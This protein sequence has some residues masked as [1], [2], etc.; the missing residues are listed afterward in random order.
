MGAHPRQKIEVP[1]CRDKILLPMGLI[2]VVYL[3][4]AVSYS[5]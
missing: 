5:G 3:K 4:L 2:R 1:E